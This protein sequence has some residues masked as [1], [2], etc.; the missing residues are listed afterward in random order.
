MRLTVFAVVLLIAAA[1]PALAGTV[2][3]SEI[4]TANVAGKLVEYIEA[5]RMRKLLLD[6]K[7]IDSERQV[8]AEERRT[9]TED[10]PDGYLSEEFLAAAY[11]ARPAAA[12]WGDCGSGRKRG[13]SL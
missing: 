2:I 10:D 7:E 12:L 3:T 9:R 8:V 5:D 1:A 4:S 6:A 13:V 11:K